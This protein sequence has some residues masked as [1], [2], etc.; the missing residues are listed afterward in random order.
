MRLRMWGILLGLG[1]L[2]SPLAAQQAGIITGTVKEGGTGR[3]L[4]GAQVSVRGTLI[5][6]TSDTAGR[7][8]MLN[9]PAGP[10]VLEVAHAGH[11]DA[12]RDVV[13]PTDGVVQ[14]E[15]QMTTAPTVL[16]ELTV[17]GS[18]QE[19]DEVKQRLDQ[20]P[21]GVDL[22]T[23]TEIRASRQANLKDVLRF[24][25]G[26]Y[27]QPRFGA[28]DESQISIRGSGLRNNFHA[29]GVNLLINGMPYRNADGF[30]D[31]EALELL[32]TE[33]IEV[34][35]G[36]NAF[37]YGGSTLGGA[38]NLI[39]RTGYTANRI[40]TFAQGGSFGLF[41]GQVASGGVQGK[42]DYYASYARTS[43]DGY[44]EWSDQ[45]RDRVNLHAG[46]RLSP[47]VDARGFYLYA[48]VKEHL[49][50]TLTVGELYHDPKA[51]DPTA[52]A[53]KYGR[54]MDLHH[55]GLQL[56]AALTPTQRLEISPY[57][58]GRDL[59]H[60]IFQVVVQ[61]TRDIGTEVRYEN[62]GAMGTHRNLFTLGLQGAH[63][64][65]DERRFVNEGGERGALTKDQND[66]VTNLAA[67]V[68]NQFG[69]S[70][71]LTLTTGLRYDHS[72]RD[73]EDH[74]LSDGDRSGERVFNNL[75]PRVG[76]MYRLPSETQ[77]FANATR[78][79]EAPLILELNSLNAGDLDGQRAWQFELGARGRRS[80]FDWELSLYDIELRD[81]LLN[82]NV[83]PFTGAPFTVPTY[84]NADKTR[85]YGV[86]LGGGVRV[87]GSLF[88]S[89]RGGDGIDLRLSYTYAK[90]RFVED[91][92]FDGN[93][94]PGQPTH[95]FNAE[96]K[97]RHP[98]G[99]SIAPT[100]EWAP[101]AYYIN[102]A[103]TQKNI[104][105][106]NLGARAE[107]T[108]ARTGLTV[109][110]GAQNLTNRINSPSVQVDNG[111]GR[112][113]EPGDRRSFYAGARWSR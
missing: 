85:H 43:L 12:I 63:L 76:L 108:P 41:K 53:N 11:A 73:T 68:E 70:D 94:I 44:R 113:F 28:A 15:I 45:A 56:R 6:T 72:K 3:I 42:F 112:S 61:K 99:F 26:V 103:N 38:I 62:T 29:R 101:E 95:F 96:V 10:K 92:T 27:I 66:K 77:L 60:P 80:A 9:V 24:S 102:S 106:L 31:F 109:F 58:Q 71:R 49:P 81:E 52:A 35:K 79:F 55:V 69:L 17:I 59:D 22:V 37:R 64:S 83:Q 5:S 97:Y 54:D 90:N 7:F 13:V 110:V 50:G 98:A 75:L 1:G 104:G 88:T 67:Y 57:F 82:I 34:Y 111:A 87:P 30:T 8:R 16:Q 84:R 40:E 107:F 33:A 105:W 74:F 93:D 32:N 100:V 46:Y 51:A 89:D 4:V 91:S 2:T 25:P 78:I 23:S 86:E 47:S 20:V 21:G 36:G 48:H 18:R 19:L 14:V 39:T 65:M